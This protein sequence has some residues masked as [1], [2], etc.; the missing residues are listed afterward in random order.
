MAS[1]PR[2]TAMPT[3]VAPVRSWDRLA[4]AGLVSTLRPAA[5]AIPWAL[6]IWVGVSGCGVWMCHPTGTDVKPNVCMA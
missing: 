6:S 1:T 2:A 4:R 5:L 3:T